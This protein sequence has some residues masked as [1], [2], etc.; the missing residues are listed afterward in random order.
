MEKRR[1]NTKIKMKYETKKWLNITVNEYSQNSS[2]K[3]K[4]PQFRLKN[5]KSISKLI[6]R[7]TQIFKKKENTQT[8]K[9]R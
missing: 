4:E 5:K 9:V 1:G 2:A 8:Q 6:M 3:N 7:H